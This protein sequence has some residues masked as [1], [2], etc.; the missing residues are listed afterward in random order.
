MMLGVIRVLEEAVIGLVSYAARSR[1]RH[2]ELLVGLVI[3]RC[4]VD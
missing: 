4:E 3:G 1:L 2:A